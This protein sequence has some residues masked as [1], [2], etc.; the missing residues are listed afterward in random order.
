[1]GFQ[2]LDKK[3]LIT[4][5]VSIKYRMWMK[6]ICGVIIKMNVIL[7]TMKIL[8]KKIKWL[9]LIFKVNSNINIQ[10]KKLLNISVG[11]MKKGFF[12]KD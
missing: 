8:K 9:Y 4:K 6:K 10:M 3:K 5:V 7:N 11:K 12:W 2:E 1:M